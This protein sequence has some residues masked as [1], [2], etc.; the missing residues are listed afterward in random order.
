[1]AHP[2]PPHSALFTLALL[3]AAAAATLAPTSSQA[4]PVATAQAQA[5]A[6]GGALSLDGALQPV[7]QATLAA[8]TGGNVLSL[9]V[10]AGDRVRAGQAIARVDE[11]D[12]QAGLLRS[13]AA[14]AQAEAEARNVRLA[15]ERTRELRGQGFVSPAALDQAETS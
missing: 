3:A 5:G 15:A 8:Q 13:E 11:R 7:R 14:L 12:A 4:A 1:M 9:A 2:A 10:K 6:A